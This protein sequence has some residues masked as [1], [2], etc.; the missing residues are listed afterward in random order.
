[1]GRSEK[2]KLAFIQG[3]GTWEQRTGEEEGEL[4]SGKAGCFFIIPP[5]LI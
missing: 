4:G 1:M 5:P 3:L 2:G